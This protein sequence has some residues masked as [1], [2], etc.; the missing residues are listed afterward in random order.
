MYFFP[1]IRSDPVSLPMNETPS[2]PARFP[3]RVEFG[4][5]LIAWIGLF[6]W[7][8]NSTFGYVATPSL[9]AWL[10]PLYNA[11]PDDGIG[12]LAPIVT[13]WML[14]QRRKE[15]EAIEWKPWAPAV[16]W[17]L[18]GL[19]LHL[20]GYQ[21]QQGRVSVAGFLVGLYGITGAYWGRE[22]LRIAGYPFAMLVFCIPTS[23][24]LATL[25]FHLRVFVAKVATAFCTE[26]LQ[27]HIIRQGTEVFN[28]THD[29]LPRFRFEVA[30][31]CS[32]IRSLTAV[33]LLVLVY[34]FLFFRSPAR[35]LVLLLSAPLLAVL[36]NIVRLITVF[37]VGEALGQ[38]AGAAIETGFGFITFSAVTVGGTL[39]LGRLLRESPPAS[40]APS[41]SHPTPTP[42]PA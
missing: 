37:I 27:M 28:A 29:G 20:I 25:T 18:L 31:A 5:V 42:S 21:I 33:I 26:V 13:V 40:P 38:Q 41:G 19:L 1:G 34:S 32:G 35:R 36:G 14:S 17:I 3:N 24:Y 30:A 4:V 12:F 39:L 7:L 22:W 9:F 15:L 10:Y 16:G 8:G 23:V 11:N 6:H 2:Q